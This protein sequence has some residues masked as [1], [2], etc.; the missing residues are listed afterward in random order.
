MP[1]NALIKILKAINANQR[2]G[3]MGAAIA[4]AWHL[5][6]MPAGSGLWWVLFLFSM[7]LRI[8]FAVQA[9]FLALFNLFTF[10]LD[11]LLHSIGYALLTWDALQGL[12]LSLWNTPPFGLLGFN[13]TLVMGGFVFGLVTWVPLYVLA[14]RLVQLY[15]EKLHTLIAEHPVVK[16][17]FQLPLVKTIAEAYRKA[18]AVSSHL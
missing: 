14:V 9:V 17:F 1:L 3:E 5:A 10:L 18:D 4:I 6:L 11:P 2:P 12:W 15:R 8:N 7:F 16:G 13:N